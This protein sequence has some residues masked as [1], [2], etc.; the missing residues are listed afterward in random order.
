MSSTNKN[1]K[2]FPNPEKFDPTSYEDGSAQ[3]P[4]TYV[5]FRGGPRMCPEKSMLARLAILTFVHNVVRK[6]KWEIMFHNEEM[7]V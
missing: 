3:A 4:Y 2:Y 5:P 6:F 7:I 1:P